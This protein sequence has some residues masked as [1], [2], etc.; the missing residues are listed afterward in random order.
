MKFRSSEIRARAAFTLV[1][2]LIVVLIMGILAAAVVQHSN[3]S[4][5][6]AQIALVQ[7][8]IRAIKNEVEMQRALTGEFPS[9]IKAEWFASGIPK[10]PGNDGSVADIHVFSTVASRQHPQY[11]IVDQF[12]AYWYN[13]NNGAVRARVPEQRTNAVTLAAYNY[14]NNAKLTS[15]SD[16]T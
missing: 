14:V 9:E 3:H 15:L 2:V 10:H 8:H 7:Q 5:Q 12:G 16:T 6:D 1:E 4:T 13:P 11:K